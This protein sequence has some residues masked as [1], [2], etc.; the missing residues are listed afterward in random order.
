MADNL[1]WTALHASAQIGSYKLVTYF[2]DIGTDIHLKT[3]DGRNCLH[4]AAFEGHLNLCKALIDRHRFDVHV[5]DNDGWTA[6]HFSAQSGSY[7]LVAYFADI[8][9]DIHLKTNDGRNCLHIAAFEGHLNLCKMLIDKYR[10]DVRVTDNDG[11][12]ALHFSAQSGSYQLVTYFAEMGT[13]IHLKTNDGKNCLHIA[14]LKGHLNLCK[15]LIDKHEF[16]V[17]MTNNL[18]WTALH[19]SARIGSYELVAYFVDMGTDIRLKINDGYNCLHIAALKGHLNLCKELIDTHKFDLHLTNNHGWTALH[20]SVQNGSYEL[21]KYFADMRTNIRKKTNHGVNCLHIAASQGNLNLC[22]VLIDKHKFDF[23]I[24]DNYGWTALHR[25]VENGSYELFKY[26][27]DMG[28]DIHLKTN[29]GRNC[30]HIAALKGNLNICKILIDKHKFDVNMTIYN[31]RFTALH[32]AAQSGSSELVTYFANMGTDIHLKTN[33]GSNCLHFAALKGHLNLC[34]VLI[35]KHKFDLHVTDNGGYTA[36]HCSAQSGNYELVAYFA[37]MGIDI[38]HKTNDGFNCLHIAASGGHLNLCK[39]LIDK[40]DFDVNIANNRGWTALHYSALIGSYELVTYFADMGTDIY[41]K[42]NDGENCLHIAA[43]EGHLNL[44]KELIDKRKFD[45]HITANNGWQALHFSVQNGSYELLRYLADMGTDIHVKT[46]E[47]MNCLHIAASEGHLNLCKELID[48]YKFDVNIADN[49][50]WTA[51]HY[52]ALNGSY[53]LVTYFAEMGTD[54]HL[55][56][57]DGKNCLHIAALKGHLNLCKVL[58]DKHNVDWHMTNNHGSYELSKYFADIGTDIHN[59]TNDGANYLHIAALKGNLNLCKELIDKHKFDLH[60]TDDRGWTALHYSVL[61]GSYELF[62]YFASMGTDIHLKTNDGKNCLHIAALEGDLDLC[63]VLIDKHNFD[64]NMAENLGSTALHFSAQNGSYE[65]FT[66]FA[67]SVTDIH[68]KRNDGINCLHIFASQGHLSLC[69]ELVDKY[70]FDVNMA[71]N[72]GWSALHCSAQSGSYELVIYF[73]DMG[74]DIHL[75]TN[76]GMNCLHIAASQGHLKLCKIL[77][78]KHKFDVNMADNLDSTAFHCSAQ[79]GSYELFTYFADMATDIYLKTNDGMNCLHI[80]ASQGH[81]HLCKDLIDKCNFDVNIADNLGWTGLHFSAKTGSY[82]LVKYFADMGTD[83]YLKTDDGMNCLHIAALTGHLNLCKMLI[84][85]HKFDVKMADY[86]GWRAFHCSAQTGCYELVIYLADLGTDIHL[87]TNGGVN[88]LHI[89]ANGGHLNLCKVL[90]DKHKFDVNMATN[91]GWT[92]LHYSVQ[93]GSYELVKY[94]AD[95]GTDIHHKTS[96]GTNCLHI[97]AL[98]GHLK[99]CKYFLEIHNFDVNMKDNEGWTPLHKSAKNGSFDVFSYI[100]G[101]GSEIYCKTNNMKNVLHFSAE[102]GHVD[103]CE[104]VLKHFT[105]DYK[106]NNIRNQHTLIGQFYTSQVFYKYN[107]IFLH[108]MDNDG[109]T[110]LHLAAGGN[111]AKVCELLLK[112][113]TEVI[114]LLNKKNETARKI[115]EERNHEEVLTLLKAEYDRTGMFLEVFFIL[116]KKLYYLAF[117][118]L[119][120][121][122]NTLRNASF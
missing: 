94:I 96:D 37:D 82:E 12:T 30:L 77:I 64:V 54:I 85:K 24:T 105:K 43:F 73:S 92:A 44:C 115:A 80:A 118:F 114:T 72:L 36:F 10:F 52:S 48:K 46:N 3:N 50:G 107:T 119:Y 17:N 60:I 78:D 34:K 62:K 56:T 71:D 39:A 67:D 29:D 121:V 89:A 90:I 58:I 31:D 69:K 66:Y 38:H 41:L 95:M 120:I 122:I 23:Q 7:K 5:T 22:K 35:D 11:W 116:I 49:L 86:L 79:N 103:I 42:T 4:I 63:K 81:L 108:A 14:A 45:F 109:N 99:L 111:Q 6:L 55:K 32:Y 97:A 117:S 20:C 47:E 110:Y 33:D 87:K 59:K 51:L 28:T 112:Y 70:K 75:K 57:N 8:G 91:H 40:H 84:D 100:L 104:F 2:A 15:V 93:S 61:S 113:D 26:F 21:F 101:K 13:D 98:E 106:E 1:E 9:T 53:E 18:G 88:C 68:L 16:D 74:T 27:A 83:I 25:S 65:L 19:F 102:N 76:E